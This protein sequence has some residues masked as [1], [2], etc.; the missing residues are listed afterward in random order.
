MLAKASTEP[1]RRAAC[2]TS[3]GD[4]LQAMPFAISNVVQLSYGDYVTNLPRSEIVR[5]PKQVRDCMARARPATPLTPS[6]CG[7][8]AI[9]TVGAAFAMFALLFISCG[10]AYGAEGPVPTASMKPKA[11]TV[12]TVV[13]DGRTL[14][15]VAGVF[16]YPA[17]KRAAAIAQRIVALA[18]NPEFS[19]ESLHQSEEAEHVKILSGKVPILEVHDVDARLEGLDRVLAARVISD[20]IRQAVLDYRDERRG[21][22]LAKSSA[23]AIAAIVL[24]W[25]LL[26]G[27]RR[28]SDRLIAAVQRRYGENMQGLHIK[29]FEIMQAEQ[30]RALLRGLASALWWL[31]AFVLVY[32]Y[33]ERILSRFPWT[34][35]FANWL[36]ELVLDPLRTMRAAIVETIPDL[37]FL[38]LLVLLVRYVLKLT[39]L[40][41]RAVSQGSVHL[42]GFEAEW[43]MPTYILLRFAIVAFAVVISFPYLPGS[44]SDA[45]KGVSVFVGV[46][47]SLG[48]S[49][50][51][52]N[53]LAGY[54]LIYRKAYGVGDR[55]MIGKY[56]GDVTVV[57]QQVTHLLTPKNEEIIIPNSMILNSEIVNYSTLA[58][59]AKL[60]L[61]TA[62]T[63]GY[64]IPWRQVEA[65]LLE[66]ARRTTGLLREPVPFVLKTALSDFYIEYEIN[67]CCNDASAMGRLYSSLH[68][69]IVDVF[70]EHGV[71]I[72]SPHFET[73]PDQAVVVPQSQWYAPPAR[74]PEEQKRQS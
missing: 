18:Q 61:H 56:V 51:V 71:Q 7:T 73:Q 17:D 10:V 52:S 32:L 4:V 42:S 34:R 35:G 69:N 21:P 62:V 39:K 1:E 28:T 43:A 65:M 5:D 68:G 33:L 11:K 23:I 9:R 13:I 70:N 66:A 24:I 72:M 22:Y 50:I 20:R 57:R 53:V 44:S 31:A 45:F 48:S 58:R 64:D 29:N 60:V 59:Q 6:R 55:V 12:A 15:P 37:V 46:L 38:V 36:L 54:N 67:A 49:A 2:G 47:L 14:F 8:K 41:F 26:W 30:I 63:I 19:V 25:L 16:A 27:L 3:K 74:L 40:F